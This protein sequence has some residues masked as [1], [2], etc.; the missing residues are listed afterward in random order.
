MSKSCEE[1]KKPRHALTKLSSYEVKTT[2]DREKVKH[3]DENEENANRM[4]EADLTRRTFYFSVFFSF[5]L[6]RRVVFFYSTSYL[7]DVWMRLLS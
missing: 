6:M 4:R 1:R 2:D 3:C 5:L 7:T